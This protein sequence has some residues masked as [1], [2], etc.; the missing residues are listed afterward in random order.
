[1][2]LP[3]ARLA[4]DVVPQQ[5]PRGHSS[6][7]RGRSIPRELPPSGGKHPASSGKAPREQETGRPSAERRSRIDI[8][9]DTRREW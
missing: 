3:R 8:V 9:G 4:G 6:P 2:S 1:M 7:L 5:T